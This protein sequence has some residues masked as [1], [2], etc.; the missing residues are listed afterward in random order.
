VGGREREAIS[1]AERAHELDPA[2]PIITMTLGLVH[3]YTRQY[4]QAIEVC[5]EVAKENPT[6]AFAHN[7]LAYGYWGKRMYPQV[8]EEWKA[9]GQLSGDRNETEFASAMEQG[10]RAAGWKGA[11]SKGFSVLAPQLPSLVWQAQLVLPTFK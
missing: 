10:F 9:Y 3:I 1:E 7:C 2:S 8:I 4:D 11:L 6:F 5:K